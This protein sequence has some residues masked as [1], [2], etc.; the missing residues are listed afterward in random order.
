MFTI[1]VCVGAGL[2]AKVSSSIVVVLLLLSV[3]NQVFEQAGY[4]KGD[5]YPTLLIIGLFVSVL[6]STAMFPFKGWGLYCTSALRS[7]TGGVTFDYGSF[8]IVSIAF[9][10]I[11]ML[12][13]VAFMFLLRC[14]VKGMKQL[15]ISELEEKHAGGLNKM[16]KTI[17]LL[18]CLWVFGSVFISLGSG[19]EGF[20]LILR[21]IGVY[22]VT[23]A[24]IAAL[25]I[26]RVDGKNIA[27]PKSVAASVQWDTV[28]VMAS[29]MFAAGL[30][31]SETTG[32]VATINVYL[33]PIFE[34]RSEYVFMVL[35]TIVCLLLT[36]LI[37][38]MTM[39]FILASVI[40]SMFQGGLL[41]DVY[42]AGM[43]LTMTT[44]LGFYTPASSGFGAMLHGSEYVTSASV[45]KWG[46]LVLV[47][48]VVAFAVIVVPLSK[49]AF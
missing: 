35:L 36:N 3:F 6:L 40:G 47:Y 5:K 1:L 28:F 2:V 27:T 16:Q 8:L 18:V 11:L 25:M 31:T 24:T 7:A 23:L 10:F 12:G 38:N 14:D 22:G 26:I 32:V 29:G 15:D 17:L 43:I 33:A 20:R 9:Y 45:Y 37:N 44:I 46:A 4:K 13:Y 19:S 48:I 34:G 21:N 49:L 30:L 41:T 42:T 39:M